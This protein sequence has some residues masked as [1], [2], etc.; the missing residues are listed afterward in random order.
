MGIMLSAL[1]DFSEDEMRYRFIVHIVNGNLFI[2]AVFILQ[3]NTDFTFLFL[4]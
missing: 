3:F 1:Q 4:G 2:M